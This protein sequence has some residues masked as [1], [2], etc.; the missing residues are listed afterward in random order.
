MNSLPIQN[1]IVNFLEPRR[2]RDLAQ[3][4]EPEKLEREM[5][6]LLVEKTKSKEEDEQTT[7]AQKT[8]EKASSSKSP[9]F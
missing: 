7:H 2:L 6:I 8:Q 5:S 3:K 1:F 9:Y 4:I